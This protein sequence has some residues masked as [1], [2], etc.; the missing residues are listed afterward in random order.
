MRTNALPWMVLSALVLPSCTLVLNPER[1]WNDAGAEPAVDAPGLDAPGLDAPG[2][3]APTAV[4]PDAQAVRM[5]PTRPNPSQAT[6]QITCTGSDGVVVYE[7]LEGVPSRLDEALRAF[8]SWDAFAM[9]GNNVRVA[10]E[11]QDSIQSHAIW[12][13]AA[14]NPRAMWLVETAPMEH[15]F[16]WDL[17]VAA[18]TGVYVAPT[19]FIRATAERF[20]AG[21]GDTLVNCPIEAA[22]SVGVDRCEEVAPVGGGPIWG[23]FG[24][25]SSTI[26][27]QQNGDTV[28]FLDAVD[29]T[30][31]STGMLRQPT[32]TGSSALYSDSTLFIVGTESPDPIVTPIELP[33]PANTRVSFDGTVYQHATISSGFAVTVSTC[34]SAVT[35]CISPTTT[36]ISLPRESFRDW[37]FH[38]LPG[39]VRVAV[40]LTTD[41]NGTIPGTHVWV[42]MWRAGDAGPVTPLRIA[43][44]RLGSLE[45]YGDGRS[46]ESVAQLT[47][48]QLDVYVSALVSLFDTAG[49][50]DHIY[51]SGFRLCL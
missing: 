42:A 49:S 29:G 51:V 28:T 12:M 25:A 20:I 27:A 48:G 21:G 8:P 1:R 32:G 38:A 4:G 23:G 24:P 13:D 16:D 31:A 41:M 19:P 26:A 14:L 10:D 47:D 22:V 33:S 18:P 30:E 3:D 2:L 46:I 15:R 50:E 35:D 6:V 34:A 40:L 45:N 44:G 39:G 5:S 7:D 9:L 37:N 43:S 11:P 36:T 17:G